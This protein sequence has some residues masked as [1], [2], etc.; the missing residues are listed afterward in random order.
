MSEA[1][2]AAFEEKYPNGEADYLAD[3]TRYTKPDGTPFY[4]VLLELPEDIYL[5]KVKVDIDNPEDLEKWLEGEEEAEKEQVAGTEG[6]GADVD[7]TIP[8][9]NLSTTSS[10]DDAQEAPE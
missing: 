4:A 9:D 1:V 8:D 10:D 6:D 2:A 3:I 7:A 5:I